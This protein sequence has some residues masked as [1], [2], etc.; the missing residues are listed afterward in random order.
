V[1]NIKMD[2]KLLGCDGVDLIRLAQDK[3]ELQVFMNMDHNF[4]LP[5]NTG[6]FLTHRYHIQ[7]RHCSMELVNITQR[8]SLRLRA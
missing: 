1:N 3:V 6:Y 5:E 7:Q 8:Y 2:L 4:R